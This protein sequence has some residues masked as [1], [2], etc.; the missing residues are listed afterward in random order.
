MLLTSTHYDPLLVTEFQVPFFVHPANYIYY[1]NVKKIEKNK[2]IRL[3]KL[4]F[5]V[6]VIGIYINTVLN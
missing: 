4:I 1:N 2:R 5:P 6:F 3:W